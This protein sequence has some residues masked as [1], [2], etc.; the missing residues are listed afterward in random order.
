MCVCVCVLC[1]VGL[2]VVSFFSSRSGS[3]VGNFEGAVN[4]TTITCNVT[5]DGSQAETAF[6]VTN[7]RGDPIVRPVF[8]LQNQ[9]VFLISGPLNN[10]LIITNWTSE[11]DNVTLYCGTPSVLLQ[12]Y[13]T[14]RLYSKFALPCILYS[15]IAKIDN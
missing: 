9:D 12:A 3:F 10:K 4:V 7:F 1:H 6:S 13:V 11:V 2:G 8:T 14:L 5:R 15:Y